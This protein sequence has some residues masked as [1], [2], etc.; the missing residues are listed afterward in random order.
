INYQSKVMPHREEQIARLQRELSDL[1]RHYHQQRV[2]ASITIP[3]L[4]QYITSHSNEDAL[5]NPT[6]DNPFSPK[7]SCEVL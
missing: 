5:V 4:V 7:K 3:E 6:K 1:K 2:R